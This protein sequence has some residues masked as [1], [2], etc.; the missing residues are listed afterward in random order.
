MLHLNKL[1]DNQKKA[2]QQTD[3]HLY[4]SASA[5]T[6]KT[7]V[8]AQRY[9]HLLDLKKVSV[10]NILAITFTDKAAHEMKKRIFQAIISRITKAPNTKERSYWLQIKNNFRDANISTIHGFCSRLIREYSS[11]VNLDP[12]YTIIDS[13]ELEYELSI[14]IRNKVVESLRNDNSQHNPT[15][16]LIGDLLNVFT[17]SELKNIISTLILN[18]YI[19]NNIIIPFYHQ[20]QNSN[21]YLSYLKTLITNE[22]INQIHKL[23]SHRGFIELSQTKSPFSDFY[24]N[25]ESRKS[26]L[27]KFL[28]QLEEIISSIN[29]EIIPDNLKIIYEINKYKNDK[30]T[31]ALVWSQDE[32]NDIIS[33]VDRSLSPVRWFLS[34]ELFAL[35]DYNQDEIDFDTIH[36]LI[37]LYQGWISILKKNY[38]D[39]NLGKWLNRSVLTY[40]DLQYLALDLL[41]DDENTL[42]PLSIN[43]QIR[44]KYKYIMVDETQDIDYVQKKII[45]TLVNIQENDPNLF[46]VGDSKQSIYKF[47]GANIS[48]FHELQNN[49]KNNN[50]DTHE[51]TINYRSHPSIL[52]FVN[53]VFTHLMPEQI[54]DFEALYPENIRVYEDNTSIDTLKQNVEIILH[55]D[56]K[57]NEAQNIAHKILSLVNSSDNAFHIEF[58]DIAILFRSMTDILDYE[59]VLIDYGIPYTITD[60]RGFFHQQEI[61]D[62]LNILKYLEYPSDELILCALLRSPFCGLSDES[63]FWLTHSEGYK[64][65]SIYSG[66]YNFSANDNLSQKEKNKLLYF[67]SWMH[68]LL[69]EKDRM[70][71]YELLE[72]TM[73]N[74]GY[75]HILSSFSNKQ[76][77][78]RNIKDFIQIIKSFE[79]QKSWTLFEIVSYIENHSNNINSLSQEEHQE[80]KITITSIHKAKGMEYPV[81]ILPNLDRQSNFNKD[82]LIIDHHHGLALKTFDINSMKNTSGQLFNYLRELD[83]KKEVAENK[84]LLYVAMTR[85]KNILILSGKIPKHNYTIYD[86]QANFLNY[87]LD[88][89]NSK[90]NSLLKW[91]NSLVTLEKNTLT[92]KN[93][94]FDNLN[95]MLHKNYRISNITQANN[96]IE[97]NQINIDKSLKYINME[98]HKP[99]TNLSASAL[100]VYNKCPRKFYYKYIQKI[101]EAQN[102]LGPYKSPPTDILDA[103]IE[104]YHLLQEKIPLNLI[105]NIIHK[106]L[107][108]YNQDNHSLTKILEK[109]LD[110]IKLSTL[111]SPANK[112][113]IN[114]KLQNNLNQ[115]V[116]SELFTEI[117][118]AQQNYPKEHHNE[119]PFILK[120]DSTI[121]QGSIDKIYKMDNNLVKILDYKTNNFKDKHKIQSELL[122]KKITYKLQMEIYYLVAKYFFNEQLNANYYFFDINESTNAFSEKN[123]NTK[124]IL[125]DLKSTITKINKNLH[126]DNFPTNP[127]HQ[128][129]LFCGYWMCESRIKKS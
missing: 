41:S 53:L 89:L 102:T 46:I 19:L 40:D 29:R 86:T 97:S 106:L 119:F 32:I 61:K 129:C 57:E 44:S 39:T 111:A 73:E 88:S 3:K 15:D 18:Y 84:R 92:Q 17:Y 107:E 24:R 104:E 54:E 16:K 122:D 31:D 82:S 112:T 9:I 65:N 117:N 27:T 55:N 113:Y 87:I 128:D 114:E 33:T 60:T 95:I 59:K 124:T 72:K 108:I 58:K 47:R 48:D 125:N 63:I 71:I 85:A 75:M 62:C 100:L 11:D 26:P 14:W 91:T 103:P 10:G 8:L 38:R 80:N 70:H 120:I 116:H 6:G 22:R 25:D 50:N 110:Q 99:Q 78:I 37:E 42:N 45:T 96:I 35:N 49:I 7:E 118:H 34:K 4:V 13:S 115:F 5:G 93:F 68:K 83:K 1:D 30:K 52:Q 51:L 28:I 67:N 126:Q 76:Q 109:F 36:K 69:L 23:K 79:N 90:N 74:S 127:T 105:G 56:D 21:E 12:E 64:I 43:K 66:Y 98:F 101:K 81:V 20:F 123:S 2:V 121:I 77:A 94:S